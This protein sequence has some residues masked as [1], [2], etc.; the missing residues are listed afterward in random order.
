MQVCNV[1]TRLVDAT[2]FKATGFFQVCSLIG[3]IGI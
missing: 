2:L 3:A 1:L